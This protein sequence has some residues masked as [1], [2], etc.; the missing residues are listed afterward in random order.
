MMK[1]CW[2]AV[3]FAL[4]AF[5]MVGCSRKEDDSN[6]PATA[7]KKKVLHV[8]IW[9]DYISADVVHKFEKQYNCR[10]QQ[11]IFDSNEMMFAKLQ[12]GA[13]GYDVL[14]PSHY[15]IKKMIGSN[16]VLKLDKEKLPNLAHLDPQVT[17]KLD[18]TVLDYSVPYFMSYTGLAYNKLLV[19]NFEPTWNIFLRDDLKNRMTL[20]DDYSEVIGAAAKQLGYSAADLDDPEKGNERM[21]EVVKLALQW[22]KNIIKFDNEQYKNGLATGEFLVVMGYFSDLSQIVAENE[23][24]GLAIP[25]EGCMMSCDMLAISSKAKEPELAY[26]FINFLHEPENAA[27]NITD[28]FAYCPNV[29]AVSLLDEEVRED[30]SIFVG[31]EVLANSEFQP[32]LSAEQEERHLDYWQKIKAGDASK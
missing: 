31:E 30:D 20:L 21:D 8:Y 16:M 3:I 27:Q 29:D 12:A 22:R 10:V 19:E 23:D 32:E 14:C 6:A 4:C 7:K 15:F 17:S 1:K 13:A 25:N 28:V 11:D 26:A 24:L 5:I 9:A 2:L 18:E